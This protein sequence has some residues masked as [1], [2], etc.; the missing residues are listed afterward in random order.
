MYTI[1]KGDDGLAGDDLLI[2]HWALGLVT[3]WL[4]ISLFLKN[5]QGVASKS[6]NILG[7]KDTHSLSMTLIPSL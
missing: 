3:R 7:L 1:N 2:K 6:G 4:A 5:C